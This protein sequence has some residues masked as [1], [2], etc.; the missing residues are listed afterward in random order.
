M[1][2]RQSVAVR[3]EA[4]VGDAGARRLAGLR[5]DVGRVAARFQH[6]VRRVG[7]WRDGLPHRRRPQGHEVLRPLRDRRRRRLLV[8]ARL[9]LARAGRSKCARGPRTATARM[10]S[11]SAART[12]ASVRRSAAPPTTASK[13]A[14]DF[15]FGV[16][17]VLN[18]NAIVQS[19][20]T[21]YTGHGYY[22]DP[23]KLGDSR[24]DHRRTFAWLTRYNQYLPRA[25]RRCGSRTAT[26]T[27]RS[28][29]DSNMLEVAWYQPLPHGFAVTPS[30]RYYTQ[31]AAYFYYGPPLGNGFVPG[32]PYTA[33][34]RLAAFGALTPVDPLRARSSP[35]AGAPTC[36][37]PTTSSGRAGGCSAPA[38]RA[39]FRCRRAGSRWGSRRRS[40]DHAEVVPPTSANSNTM[41]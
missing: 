14:L 30:L 11:A 29:T 4:A 10:R 38:A 21:Y 28:A 6:A 36:R 19:N 17:Q 9:H 18:A 40:D 5:R 26:S 25:T 33:D 22:T 20:L 34:T 7:P 12:T 32:Q 39:S 2:V 41:F 3:A 15:L 16:T 8:R 24:P 31:S 35:T 23:Y 37:S 13:H 1:T 27:I